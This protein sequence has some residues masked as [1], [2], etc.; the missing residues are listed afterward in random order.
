MTKREEKTLKEFL[1]ALQMER[2]AIISFSLDGIIAG[3]KK[4]K[5]SC[6]SSNT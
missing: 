4:R 5:R 2:D 3:N 6:E 1:T